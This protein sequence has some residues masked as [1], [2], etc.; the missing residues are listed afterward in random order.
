MNLNK[1]PLKYPVYPESELSPFNLY[2]SGGDYFC[3]AATG[4]Y[5]DAG[6]QK[7]YISGLKDEEGAK[8]FFDLIDSTMASSQFSLTVIDRMLAGNGDKIKKY[9][10]SGNPEIGGYYYNTSISPEDDPVFT[11]IQ[12]DESKD[13]ILLDEA[14]KLPT[15]DSF[16]S[17]LQFAEKKPAA[18][19]VGGRISRRIFWHI[20][21]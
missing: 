11:L 13:T 12:I 15:F 9:P 17:M 5:D 18:W 16:K 6:Y 3:F 2:A 1:I 7:P 8:G 20:H 4:Q 10:Q 14:W 19:Q 21:M